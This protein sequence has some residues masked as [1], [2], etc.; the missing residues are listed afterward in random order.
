VKHES[1]IFRHNKWIEVETEIPNDVAAPRS[2][3][4]KSKDPY[5][6][7]LLSTAAKAFAA[8]NCPKA[9]VW[10]WIVY[11]TLAS[12]DDTIDV[13]NGALAQYG[14]SRQVKYLA[15]RQLEQEGLIKVGRETRKTCTVTIL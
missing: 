12:G 13:P 11:K 7:L 4:R 10:A 14:V 15:L 2:G 8:M 9:M 5:A 3:N 6:H 1:K